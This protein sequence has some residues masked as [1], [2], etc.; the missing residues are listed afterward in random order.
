MITFT[1]TTGIQ[2]QHTRD[3]NSAFVFDLQSNVVVFNQPIDKASCDAFPLC[4][5]RNDTIS[6]STGVYI[7]QCCRKSR[8]K[9]GISK[10]NRQKSDIRSSKRIKI[11]YQVEEKGK[12]KPLLGVAERQNLSGRFCLYVFICYLSP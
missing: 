8:N 10:E 3:I 7:V 9:L 5:A 1:H 6:P 11:N 2:F 12:R 4:S